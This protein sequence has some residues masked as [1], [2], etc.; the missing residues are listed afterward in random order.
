MSPG[1][2]TA[3]VRLRHATV[4]R[5]RSERPGL[6]ELDVVVD[7]DPA[8]PPPVAEP[9]VA[10]AFT[11]LVGRVEVGDRVLVNT[12]GVALGLGTGGFHLVV[13]VDDQTATE[14]GHPG[15]V[16]KARYTPLQAAVESVEETDREALERSEGLGGRP[17]VCA[18]LHS[19][20]G[21]IA[22]GA[23]AAGAE[24][25]AYVMS[26]G[27]ALPGRLS[28]LVPRLRVAGLLAG[29]VTSGQA[30]GG[31][32]EAVT[33]WTGVLAA[34]ELVGADVVIV[35]DGPGNLG[36]DTTWGVSA[37][38]SGHALNATE[39]LGGRRVAADVAGPVREGHERDLVWDSLRERRLEERH[40]LVEVDG[41]PALDEL[42][43]AGVEIDSMGRTASEDPAF[44]L[45]AGAAGILAGRMAA[46]S[47]RWR[48]GAG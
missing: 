42:E 43:R 37:L 6:L 38:A 48:R 14:L 27:A 44:F 47:R 28:N 4:R 15:R 39:A 21:P 17:V 13:A 35:A 31:E 45:A 10:V 34:A 1:P 25:I 24:R 40:E 19:M 11:Q 26:D 12:T 46:G 36:T 41:R 33:I 20:I 18:P 16:M 8:D 2:P 7:D 9:G 5:I 23:H 3:S 32:L 29:F 30:F 22:A